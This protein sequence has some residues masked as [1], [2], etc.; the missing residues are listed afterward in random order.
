MNMKS[1]IGLNIIKNIYYMMKYKLT[2]V[3]VNVNTFSG[4]YSNLHII[5]N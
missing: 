1:I 3:Y 5:Y 4:L 2:Y